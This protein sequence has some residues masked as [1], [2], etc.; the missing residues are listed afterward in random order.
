MRTALLVAL[1]GLTFEGAS[2]GAEPKVQMTL[3]GHKAAVN[4]VAIN[5]RETV[6]A[7][8]SDDG[9]VKLWKLST[10]KNIATFVHPSPVLSVEFDDYCLRLISGCRD[11]TVMVWNLITDKNTATLHADLPPRRVWFCSSIWARCLGTNEIGVTYSAQDKPLD[12]SDFWDDLNTGKKIPIAVNSNSINWDVV[13]TRKQG[14]AC[15]NERAPRSAH[16][17]SSGDVSLELRESAAEGGVVVLHGH[18][19][20]VND[21]AFSPRDGKWLVS[22]SEDG[23]IKVWEGATGKGMAT[24]TGH[25]GAVKCVKFSQDGKTLVSGSADAT[26]K[27]WEMRSLDKR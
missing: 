16:D 9:T 1:L 17:A 5:P 13:A 20:R 19:G 7:S 22:G 25:A 10:G 6:L 8:A 15:A 12:G 24:L 23:T 27:L 18:T 21:L 11:G 14:W 26:I 2:R 3:V 4:C